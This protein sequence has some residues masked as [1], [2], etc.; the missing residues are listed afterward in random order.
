M[1]YIAILCFSMNSFICVVAIC[2]DCENVRIEVLWKVSHDGTVSISKSSIWNKAIKNLVLRMRCNA[3]VFCIIYV[4]LKNLL[5]LL[6]QVLKWTQIF[7]KV[8]CKSLYI[9]H[10]FNLDHKENLSRILEI[11][12]WHKAVSLNGSVVLWIVFV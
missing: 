3:N 7:Y 5:R 1:N 10:I 8:L 12:I 6:I 9:Y 11:S 2:S 4:I